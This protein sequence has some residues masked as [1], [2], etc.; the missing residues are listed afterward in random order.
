[1]NLIEILNFQP[2]GDHG[3]M[4]VVVAYMFKFNDS[5]EEE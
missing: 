5:I 4:M 3:V 2:F 1:M